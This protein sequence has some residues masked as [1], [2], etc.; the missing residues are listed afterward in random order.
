MTERILPEELGLHQVEPHQW[1]KSLHL[2]A[3][4]K[5]FFSAHL[6]SVQAVI[7]RTSCLSGPPSEAQDRRAIHTCEII[8]D[9]YVASDQYHLLLLPSDLVRANDGGE[10]V[11][12]E[13]AQL[14]ALEHLPWVCH[15]VAPSLP[16]KLL[17]EE[18][19]GREPEAD[20]IGAIQLSSQPLRENISPNSCFLISSPAGNAD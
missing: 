17:Q 15:N 9:T 18:I 13:V 2:L 7:W 11:T 8:F 12:R 19:L 20:G 16:V 14:I 6:R 5:K 3:R 4:T 10:V 1:Q